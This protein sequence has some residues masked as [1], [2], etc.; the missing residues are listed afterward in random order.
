M[1]RFLDRIDGILPCELGIPVVLP[2]FRPFRTPL[3]NR[4]KKGRREAKGKGVQSVKRALI[5]SHT[6]SYL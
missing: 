4:R 5:S 3:E 2:S 6:L 1:Q